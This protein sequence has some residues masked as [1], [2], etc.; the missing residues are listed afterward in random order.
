M[1]HTKQI[2][3][4]GDDALF[5]F[6]AA[7]NEAA[8]H[9]LQTWAMSASAEELQQFCEGSM[10][11]LVV[12]QDMFRKRFPAALNAWDAGLLNTSSSSVPLGSPEDAKA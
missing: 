11:A 9:D 2:P 6:F 5:W 3:T 12:V 10:A 1:S 7:G 8:L 4:T